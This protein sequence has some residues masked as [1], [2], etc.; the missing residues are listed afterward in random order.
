MSIQPIP[1]ITSTSAPVIANVSIVPAVRPPGAKYSAAEILFPSPTLRFPKSYIYVTNRNIGVPDTTQGDSIA[2]FEHVNIG[3][4]NE[5]LK[6]IKQ[7]FTGLSQVR[8]IAIGHV[9]NGSEEFLVAAGVAGTGGV[10]VFKRVDG[11]RD[12]VEVASNKEVLTRTS[13]VW[14]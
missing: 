3:R 6:L 2:I 1:K 12:L 13:F 7:V 4:A 9:D 14:L 5:G 11:G 8:G 10:K